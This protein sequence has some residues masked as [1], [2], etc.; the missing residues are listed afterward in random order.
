MKRYAS[1]GDVKVA[2]CRKRH[3]L[4]V[5][6]QICMSKRLL[7]RNNLRSSE[8]ATQRNQQEI[9]FCQDCRSGK[10][11]HSFWKAFVQNG[12]YVSCGRAVTYWWACSKS[13]R[14]ILY[15]HEDVLY[16][17]INDGLSIQRSVIKWVYRTWQMYTFWTNTTR[18]CV[19]QHTHTHAHTNTHLDIH[20]HTHLHTQIHR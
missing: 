4:V 16:G 5:S 2:W 15:L 7:C 6:L 10:A 3:P 11:W 1:N 9:D 14:Y 18:W 8:A 19:W 12:E 17:A 20:T 13:W